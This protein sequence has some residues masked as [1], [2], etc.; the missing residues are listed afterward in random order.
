MPPPGP[1][2][3]PDDEGDVTSTVPCPSAG[4]TAPTGSSSADTDNDGAL[5]VDEQLIGEDPQA[6]YPGRVIYVSNG[7]SNANP[8]TK[9]QPIATLQRAFDMTIGGELVLFEPGTYG[10]YATAKDKKVRTSTTRFVG[11]CRPGAPV[12]IDGFQAHGGKHLDLSRFI[13][14]N[15]VVL[16]DDAFHGPVEIATADY[17]LHH[18]VFKNPWGSGT[19]LMIRSGA[20]RIVVEDNEIDGWTTGI[21]GPNTAGKFSSDI[22]IRRNVIRNLR[23][24]GIQ[25]GFW[26]NV[27]IE[28]ND[29]GQMADPEIHNDGIQ[30]TGGSSHVV[31]RRN[32]LHHSE[33]GQLLLVQPAFAPIDDVL[34]ENNLLH[35]AAGYAVQIQ[36]ST[37]TRFVNNT[38]WFSGYGGLLLRPYGS[39]VPTDY[40][41]ANNVLYGYDL[42]GVTPAVFVGNITRYAIPDPGFVDVTG[43]D[44]RLR[45]SA[46][47][48]AAGHPAY[49][50][51]VDF[52]G[53]ARGA[54][55]SAG[56]YE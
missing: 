14:T 5:D 43:R 24:D 12:K 40:V 45:S 18:N 25:F 10:D 20:H 52:E 48:K 26:N 4:D 49:N 28:A 6:P 32:R 53:A 34:I 33:H 44:F 7:G 47:A 23:S 30:F 42:D 1:P 46:A 17:R 19:A 36:G 22:T 3:P 37:N 27:L 13:F 38:V 2:V 56:A 54:V 31:I 29:I 9:A 8:G 51:E 55:P 39:T 11:L 16:T 35:D 15:D 41:V 50:P 21:G